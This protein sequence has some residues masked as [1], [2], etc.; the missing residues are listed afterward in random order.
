MQ[1]TRSLTFGRDGGPEQKTVPEAL[2]ELVREYREAARPGPNQNVELA[3]ERKRA[4]QIA[5]ATACMF[6]GGVAGMRQLFA[7]VE[8]LDADAAAYGLNHLW[9]FVGEWLS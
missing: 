3:A 1:T 2:V 8:E 5:G 7:E 6:G 4:I 9:D